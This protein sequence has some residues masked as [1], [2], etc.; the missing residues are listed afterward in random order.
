MSEL[1]GW[2]DD[3]KRHRDVTYTAAV[4]PEWVG[5]SGNDFHK[6]EITSVHDIIQNCQQLSEVRKESPPIGGNGMHV[7]S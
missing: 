7:A 5:L 1:L 6:H 2:P 3:S 4:S